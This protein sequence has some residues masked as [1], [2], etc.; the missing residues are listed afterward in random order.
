MKN[1]MN[2]GELCEDKARFCSCCGYEFVPELPEAE[3]PLPA[4]AKEKAP[5]PVTPGRIA[6]VVM[7]YIAAYLFLAG[8]DGR[9]YWEALVIFALTVVSVE[10]INKEKPRPA[11]SWVW[12]ACFAMCTVSY[13]FVIEDVWED[14]QSVMLAIAFGVWWVLSRS[15]KL[16]EGKSGHLLPADAWSGFAVIPFKNYLLRFRTIVASMRLMKSE[17]KQFTGKTWWTAAAAVACGLLLGRA[18][19]LLMDADDT[20]YKMMGNIFDVF[21]FEWD[22]ELFSNIFFSIPF[23]CLGSGLILGAAADDRSGV[24]FRRERLYRRLG[25]IR[26]VPESLW[27]WVIGMFSALY[28]A[29]FILQGSYMFGAF[30]GTLPEGFIVAE[31]ARQGFFELCKV[32]VVNAAVLWLA[33][34]MVTDEIKNEKLFKIFCLVLLA[35]SIL[36]SVI[37]FSKLALYISIYGF[38]PLRL[39]STWL[40][41][42]LFAACVMWGYTIITDRPAFRKW[43]IFSAVSFS[44]LA[45]I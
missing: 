19:G 9:Y 13:C 15:G 42:V 41:C 35:E 22:D 2:C 25:A 27:M 14:Y 31:Y 37:A 45:I 1:C 30:T 8:I 6:T 40:V 21:D 32:M 5:V 36:F 3:K 23:G 43:M 24:D 12:L 39:Q 7:S 29:F 33:T 44:I 20:F 34:R 26:R 38:T 4:Q 16:L 11:E 18:V 10:L 28:V 17:K